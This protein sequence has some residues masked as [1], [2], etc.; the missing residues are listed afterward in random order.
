MTSTVEGQWPAPPLTVQDP[1]Q[2]TPDQPAN[3]F[4][5][6]LSR[7]TSMAAYILLFISV[8][9][10]LGMR[11]PVL[12]RSLGRWRSLDLHQFTALL[13]MVLLG[14]H[15][16]SLLGDAYF[17]LGFR[18]LLVPGAAPY[19]PFWTEI[20]VIGF[21]LSLAVGLTVYIRRF[22]GNRVWRV[23]HYLAFIV[24]I[25]SLLHG[26][27]GGTDSSAAWAQWLYI[28]TGTVA[29]FLFLW[30]FLLGPGV[31]QPSRDRGN[32]LLSGRKAAA[33]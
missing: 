11:L 7:T 12:D 33:A 10:G 29:T 1:P 3:H 19:R 25:L 22:I 14:V 32:G 30:R 13:A 9:L 21:Y 31:S 24:F 8:C 26:I 23:L 17:H 20:G 28:S 27:R 2:S 15:V 6:Y 16:F 18:E 4:Y 5:W